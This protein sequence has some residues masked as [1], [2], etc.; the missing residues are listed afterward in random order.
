MSGFLIG[1]VPDLKRGT[2][3]SFYVQQYKLRPLFRQPEK[4]EISVPASLSSI[5]Q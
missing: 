1:T 5:T 2:S 3:I 4:Q